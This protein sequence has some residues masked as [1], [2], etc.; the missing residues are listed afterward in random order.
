MSSETTLLVLQAF[1][2]V[3]ADDALGESFDD[4]GLADAR[5]ADQHRVV[6][7]PARQNLDHA[8]DLLVAADDRIE[9]ALRRPAASGRGRIFREL[10]RW[11]RDS[12]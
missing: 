4:G 6:F 5:F 8:A 7:G 3:A 1:G 12:A 2:H 11:L 10:R 9:L